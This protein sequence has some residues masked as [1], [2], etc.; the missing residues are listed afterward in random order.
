MKA[1]LDA[2][3]N[4]SVL[5]GDVARFLQTRPNT[6]N[7]MVIHPSEMAKKDWCPRATWH[8][9]AGHPLQVTEKPHSLRTEVIFATG[10]DIHAKW[11]RWLQEMNVLFGHWRCRTCGTPA[12]GWSDS[13][14]VLCSPTQYHDWEY[15]EVPLVDRYKHNISGHSDGVF[16][17]SDDEV[18]MLEVKSIG[19]GTLRDLDILK[20]DD[21]E[22]STSSLFPKISRPAKAHVIQLQ[23]YLRL[24]NDFS[25]HFVDATGPIKKGLIIYENKSDQQLREFEITRN[26]KWTDPLFEHAKDITWS[27]SKG[28]EVRCPHGG[29][30]QC[31]AYEEAS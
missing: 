25:P 18:R 20:D 26:D 5:L 8:R 21:E 3:K 11:Q 23:I 30:A 17:G 31:R 6:R 28:R 16:A 7:S 24:F 29:C 4:D 9:I 14:P 15:M 10:H 2:K 1:Y 27:L 12:V 19:P 22:T 13:I